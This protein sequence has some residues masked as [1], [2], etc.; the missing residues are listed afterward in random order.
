MVNPLKS[1]KIGGWQGLAGIEDGKVR[2]QRKVDS[3]T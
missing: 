1:E 3:K 2:S